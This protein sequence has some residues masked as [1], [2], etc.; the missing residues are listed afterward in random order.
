MKKSPNITRILGHLQQLSQRCSFYLFFCFVLIVAV[1]VHFSK[2]NSIISS[3][4]VFCYSA[5]HCPQMNIIN[6]AVH[7]V[8]P[9]HCK[10]CKT[11][12]DIETAFS[13]CFAT[14]VHLTSAKLLLSGA[15]RNRL[16]PPHDQKLKKQQQQK[17][18]F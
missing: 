8:S 9:L 10:W 18:S 15:R 2:C 17:L 3:L 14:H 13:G 6:R 7:L 16:C 4:S 1:V 11:L 5:F 12:T